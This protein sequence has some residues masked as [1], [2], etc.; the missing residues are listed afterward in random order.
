MEELSASFNTQ[1]QDPDDS[2]SL[3]DTHGQ[4]RQ[5]APCIIVDN[6][7]KDSQVL[8][9][10]LTKQD[11]LHLFLQLGSQLGLLVTVRFVFKVLAL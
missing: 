2:K 9:R 10:F 5:C 1:D 7:R 8:A 6:L 3:D 4:D 11:I